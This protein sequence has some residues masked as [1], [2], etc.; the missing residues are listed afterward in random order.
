MRYMGA[1]FITI[2]LGKNVEA[3]FCGVGGEINNP[4]VT[5]CIW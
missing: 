4:K 3:R 1:K 5:V 2:E